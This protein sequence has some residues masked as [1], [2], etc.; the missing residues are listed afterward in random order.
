M[1]SLQLKARLSPPQ[2]P[3][4]ALGM[5]A[6]FG[7]GDLRAA[8]P[9]LPHTK[10]LLQPCKDSRGPW[11]PGPALPTRV[12][13]PCALPGV[14]KHPLA[15]STC[16]GRSQLLRAHLHRSLVPLWGD[17]QLL[18][19]LHFGEK[20]SEIPQGQGVGCGIHGQHTMAQPGV[21]AEEDFRRVCSSF[22]FALT[23]WL[24]IYQARAKVLED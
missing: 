20:P 9:L 21:A 23:H 6:A 5:K 13:G 14:V 17:F 22:I 11:G 3:F 8:N 1:A 7:R 2:L 15:F 12:P 16:F 24:C 10:T 18:L 19:A 4:T